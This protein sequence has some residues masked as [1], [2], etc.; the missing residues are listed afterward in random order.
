ME[1]KTK[2]ERLEHDHAE[3]VRQI[4]TDVSAIEHILAPIIEGDPDSDTPIENRADS[5]LAA[6]VM[7]RVH[8]AEHNGKKACILGRRIAANSAQVPTTSGR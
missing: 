7:R 2:N 6:E 8:R 3:L 4:E 1:T 5:A